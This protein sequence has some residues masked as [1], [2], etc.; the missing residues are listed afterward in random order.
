MAEKVNNLRVAL[1]AFHGDPSTLT[2]KFRSFSLL[3]N[4]IL[5]GGKYNRQSINITICVNTET[6]HS[7]VR[8]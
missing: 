4:L 5:N 1:Y 3:P 2:S 7:L 8:E 6:T